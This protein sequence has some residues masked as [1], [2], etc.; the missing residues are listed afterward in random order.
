M[1]N[2]ITIADKQ[3]ELY[4]THEKILTYVEALADRMNAS[5]RGREIFFIGILNG[6]F[7]FAADLLKLIHLK[8]RITF[9]KLASYEGTISSGKVTRIIGIHEDIRDQTVVVIEDIVDTGITLD[10]ILRQLRGYEPRE[11]RIATMFHKPE[12]YKMDL[13]LDYVG[14]EIP[15]RFIVGYGLDYEGYG[16]NLQDLY[17]LK[18]S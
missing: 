15:N 6:A 13:K 18:E 9:V 4:I 5:L 11:I 8:C 1:M 7:I 10:H 14:M 12:A 17:I 2:E 3:F 16:R